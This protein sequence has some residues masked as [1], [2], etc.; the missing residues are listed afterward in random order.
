VPW[1]WGQDEVAMCKGRLGD[2]LQ[3][4][5]GAYIRQNTFAMWVQ[6]N[7]T[8]TPIIVLRRDTFT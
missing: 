3:A 6:L 1:N 2:T 4:F 8:R 7:E 5:P